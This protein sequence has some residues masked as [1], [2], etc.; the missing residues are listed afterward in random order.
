M[1]SS[2]PK[3]VLLFVGADPEPVVVSPSFA[4][5]GAVVPSDLYRVN[6]SLSFEAKGWVPQVFTEE[7]KILVRKFLNVL[8]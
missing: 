1:K 3:V 6:L 8:R 5:D 7:G 2:E 4:S